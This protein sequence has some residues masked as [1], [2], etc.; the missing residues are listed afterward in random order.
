MLIIRPEQVKVLEQYMVSQFEEQMKIHLQWFF[1]EELQTIGEVGLRE[2]IR[3]GVKKAQLYQ[4]TKEGDVQ[5]YLE[6]AVVYGWEFDT[7]SWAKE[8]LQ[9][10]SG[11]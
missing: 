7:T 3:L 5:R 2:Q 9:L 4:I 10:A 1:S 11:V 6:C 8:I